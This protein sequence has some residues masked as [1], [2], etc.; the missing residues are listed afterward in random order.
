MDP[1]ALAVLKELGIAAAL[2]LLVGLER[3]RSKS[4]GGALEVSTGAR[5]M[6]L[7]ALWG[8]LAARLAKSLA[9]WVLPISLAGLICLQV[10]SYYM[11]FRRAKEE[12]GLTT[13]VSAIVTFLLGVL[14]HEG[15]ALAAVAAAVVMTALLA[16]KPQIHRFARGLSQE[17]VLAILEFVV[18]MAIVLPL[19]P[20][21][22]LDPQGA[23]RPREVGLMITL[24]AGIGLVGFLLI[25]FTGTRKGLRT[26]AALAGLVSSTALVFAFSRE[27]RKEPGAGTE[28]GLGMALACTIMYARTLAVAAVTGP[29]ILPWLAPPVLA[30]LGASYGAYRLIS[31]RAPAGDEVPEGFQIKNPTELSMA[32]K[33]GIF[34]AAVRWTSKILV[35]TFGS[36]ALYLLALVA[37]TSDVDAI[38]I[39]M[40][41]MAAGE[42][43]AR[44]AAH[45]V[46][47]AAIANNAVKMGVAAHWASPKAWKTLAIPLAAGSA[48]GLLCAGAI[49]LF[50]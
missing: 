20:S 27:S 15:L 23:I 31:R 38:T 12:P 14:V 33:F 24:L 29:A 40:S 48:A 19:L 37:G 11:T 9:P 3:E 28:L 1:G 6:P 25:H 49:E 4:G 47:L 46:V 43:P 18:L 5:T 44:S 32:I 22:P 7:I 45:A 26:T 36:G 39:S 35:L 30:M 8:A 42:L 10:A 21:E 2:G 50:F 16:F 17:H 41:R 34:Y 13:Y